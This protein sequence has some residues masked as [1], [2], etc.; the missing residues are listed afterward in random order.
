MRRASDD[1]RHGRGHLTTPADT[2]PAD[3]VPAVS[4]G[5]GEPR[6]G[7]RRGRPALVVVAIVVIAGAAAY[8]LRPAADPREEGGV[9]ELDEPFPGLR[10]D[11]VV[12]P[13][14]DTAS[15]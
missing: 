2:T 11:A 8:L 4:T 9:A 1:D 7:A 10:G 12:G 3:A 6:A 15:L 13:P 14:V 5:P